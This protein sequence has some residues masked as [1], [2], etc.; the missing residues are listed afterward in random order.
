MVTP[1]PTYAALVTAVLTYICTT[2]IK[3]WPLTLKRSSEL[4]QLRV[5]FQL[6]TT[7]THGMSS[8]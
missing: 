4:I 2:T 3:H 1:A 7:T 6:P 5:V 8:E